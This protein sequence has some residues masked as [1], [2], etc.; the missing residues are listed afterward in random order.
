MLK[1]FFLSLL[2]IT[3]TAI[4]IP[5]RIYAADISIGGTTWYTAWDY[6]DDASFDVE[7]D[8]SFLYGPVLSVAMTQDLSASF[9]F[10]YGE[11]D[12]DTGNETIPLTRYDS[13]LT[14]NYRIN[15][16]FKIFAGGKL[17]GFAWDPE[18]THQAL[19][20]GAGISSIFPLGYDFFLLGYASGM[21]LWGEEEDPSRDYKTK[22]NEYGF[23]A[24]MSVAYYIPVASITISLGGRYQQ[25]NIKYDGNND[26]ITP[27]S[28][29]RFY[30]VTLTAVY[31]F[32]I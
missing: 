6:E 22:T 5:A 12:M 11:F 21:Y 19:G 8:P 3:L 14:L 25:I 24:S 7:Y 13:D 27:D 1:K 10:L 23:N 20:S 18:G 29:S 2:S 16:Y 15:N 4:I 32:N 28:E 9:V 30:G 26:E 17:I 31:T